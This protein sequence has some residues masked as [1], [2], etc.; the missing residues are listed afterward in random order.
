M[1]LVMVNDAAESVSVVIVEPEEPVP[2]RASVVSLASV[3]EPMVKFAGFVELLVRVKVDGAVAAV[4]LNVVIVKAAA[5]L[6]VKAFRPLSVRVPMVCAA[7]VVMFSPAARLL[8]MLTVAIPTPS[9]SANVR[10]VVLID[11]VM[12]VVSVAPAESA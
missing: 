2:A 9:A 12:A 8:V 4:W 3:N 6:T 5:P 1:A 11:V 10:A 7:L